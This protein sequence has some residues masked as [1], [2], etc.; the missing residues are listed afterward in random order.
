MYV[1]VPL[2]FKPLKGYQ[3][4]KAQY[5]CF[6]EYIAGQ[7]ALIKAEATK[8][9]AEATKIAVAEATKKATAAA[10]KKATAAAAKKIEDAAKKAAV[11]AKKKMREQEIQKSHEVARI[12]LSKGMSLSDIRDVTGLSLKEL[13]SIQK[14]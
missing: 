14:S 4:D 11:A 13:R 8:I 3:K 1:S 7:A 9:A 10:T 12:L 6:S 5:E 2:G